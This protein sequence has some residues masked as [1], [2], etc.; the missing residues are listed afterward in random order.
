[1]KGEGW[2]YWGQA[3]C[4]GGRAGVTGGGRMKEQ[5]QWECRWG[6]GILPLALCPV[7]LANAAAQ[8]V[9]VSERRALG[10]HTAPRKKMSKQSSFC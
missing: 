7:A 8:C 2:V 5:E 1:M 3:G 10:K 9:S 4:T 6:R